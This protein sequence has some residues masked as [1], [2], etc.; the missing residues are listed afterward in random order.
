MVVLTIFS[1]VLT[2]CGSLGSPVTKGRVPPG[3][4][5]SLVTPA[6]QA[7]DMVSATTGWAASSTTVFRTTTAGYQFPVL[8]AGTIMALRPITN[9]AAWVAWR[10]SNQLITLAYTQDGGVQWQMMHL[11]A[12]WPDVQVSLAVT[13]NGTMGSVLATGPAS[14]ATAPQA[15]WI[16]HPSNLSSS[17]VVSISTGRM[18]Y[19][20]WSS[21]STI[22]ATLVNSSALLVPR[23]KGRPGIR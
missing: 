11:R 19:V 15:L 21:D 20:A 5:S 9:D 17:P 23:D 1:L 16:G 10:K 2:A 12:P 7:L 22:W 14:T 18:E 3:S 6:F 8:H 13:A 4:L